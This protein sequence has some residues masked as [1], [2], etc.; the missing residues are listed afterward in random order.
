MERIPR[1]FPDYS[2]EGHYLD[3]FSTPNTNEDGSPREIDDFLPRA[4]VKELF[5]QGEIQS[6]NI[7]K[8]EELSKELCVPVGL[9]EDSVKHCEELK[10]L[11]EMR[12]RTRNQKKEERDAKVYEDYNWGEL[13]KSGTLQ[14][15]TVKELNKYMDHHQLQSKYM[16][17][18]DRIRCITCHYYRATDAEGEPNEDSDDSEE[19]SWDEE[20]QVESDS[21][22]D[23]VLDQFRDSETELEEETSVTRSGRRICNKR[24][25]EGDWLFY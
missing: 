12:S 23:I 16:K 25:A 5:A 7:S 21:A 17:K 11:S 13:I 2:K 18:E 19:G 1:P 4:R 8:L 6:S 3:V 22:E 14:K 9:L 15:L 20:D 10:V 24:G